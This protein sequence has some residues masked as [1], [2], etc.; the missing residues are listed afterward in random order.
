MQEKQLWARE[1]TLVYKTSSFYRHSKQQQMPSGQ[2]LQSADE[3]YAVASTLLRE[4]LPLELRLMGVRVSHFKG[5]VRL[6]PQEGQSTIESF[7]TS[8]RAVGE[9]KEVGSNRC[10]PAT[11][12]DPTHALS[13]SV[14]S[15]AKKS[16]SRVFASSHTSVVDLCDNIQSCE[17]EAVVVYEEGS[18]VAQSEEVL[19]PSSISPRDHAN[20]DG[21]VKA[22]LTQPQTNWSH[23]ATTDCNSKD[24][25]F[26]ISPCSISSG[27]SSKSSTVKLS[28]VTPPMMCPVCSTTFPAATL[29]GEINAHLDDCLQKKATGANHTDCMQGSRESL[30]AKDVSRK[31]SLRKRLRPSPKKPRSRIACNSI[32]RMF[33]PKT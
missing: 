10:I 20:A 4:S 11:E 5:E 14:S 23:S 26:N 15:A 3:I 19:T 29:N 25:A 18:R 16:P 1:V 6:L 17:S 8:A 27:T 9:I 28:L 31:S 30:V 33:R 21:G 32:I 13:P 24:T 7:L 22:S 12:M 2:W